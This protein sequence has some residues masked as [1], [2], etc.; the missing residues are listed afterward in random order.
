TNFDT[1]LTAADM[2]TTG[3]TVQPTTSPWMSYPT[4]GSQALNAEGLAD[5]VIQYARGCTFGTGELTTDSAPFPD[6]NK[7]CET[8]PWLLGDIFHSDPIVV[9][10][11]PDRTFGSAY[12]AFRAA[13]LNRERVIYTG[14]NAGFLEGIQAGTWNTTTGVYDTG[15]GVE[16][17]GF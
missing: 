6:G 17:F 1:A 9:R 13:Y 11:P 4:E 3:Y 12:D 8:R 7:P 10:N 5:E 2:N 16:K 15:T 14:T